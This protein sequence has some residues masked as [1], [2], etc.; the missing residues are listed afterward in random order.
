M[1]R[2]FY[3]SLICLIAFTSQTKIIYQMC[4]APWGQDRLW[5]DKDKGKDY[6]FCHDEEDGPTFFDGKLITLTA[7]G[8]SSFGVPCAEEGVCTPGAINRLIINHGKDGFMKITNIESADGTKK[9][10]DVALYLKDHILL[11]FYLDGGKPV[12]F[13]VFDVIKET[14]ILVGA[15]QFADIVNVPISS[16]TDDY[17]GWKLLKQGNFLE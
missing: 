13:V 9:D 15:N 14:N 1:R 3:L 7:N 12:W 8:L 17:M 11:N 5:A 16:L 4:N 2:T 6:T 10:V